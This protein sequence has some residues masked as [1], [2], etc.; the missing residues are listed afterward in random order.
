MDDQLN[1]SA[2]RTGRVLLAVGGTFVVFVLT[3]IALYMMPTLAAFDSLALAAWFVCVGV[4]AFS[5]LLA[6][7]LENTI[8][9]GYLNA[10]ALIVWLTFGLGMALLLVFVGAAL[11]LLLRLQ[12]ARYPGIQQISLTQAVQLL[13]QRISLT[14]LAL[15]GAALIYR[16]LGYTAP[17]V[18]GGLMLLPELMAIGVAFVLTQAI[19]VILADSASR[20]PTVF[21]AGQRSRLFS[22]IILMIAIVPLALVYDTSGPVVFGLLVALLAVQ[23]FRHRQVVRTQQTLMVRVRELSLINSVGQDISGHLLRD[24]VIE[25][26]REWSMSTLVDTP[27]FFIGLYDD[28]RNLLEYPLVMRRGEPIHWN[29]R[30]PQDDPFADVVFHNRTMVIL[31]RKGLMTMV[32]TL[33]AR[34]PDVTRYVGFPLV[35]G[36]KIIGVMGFV[37]DGRSTLSD[38]LSLEAL[39]T[40]SRQISLSL[41]NAML[42]D[43][44]LSLA[45]NLNQINRS[46][47]D[48]MFNLDSKSSLRVACE[49]AMQIMDSS[50]VAIF[51]L[52]GQTGRMTRLVESAGLTAAHRQLYS[53]PTYL[54]PPGIATSRVIPDIHSLDPDEISDVLVK[55]ARAGGFRAMAEVPLKSGNIPVGMLTVFHDVPYHY[56]KMQLELLETL[57][58]QVA[59]A[60]DNAELLSALELYAAEQ[61]QL[62]HLSRIS[63]S[64]LDIDTVMQGVSQLLQQM[65]SVPWVNIGLMPVGTNY[66]QFYR[67]NDQ[68]RVAIVLDELPEVAMVCR[69]ALPGPSVYY[70]GEPDI[71]LQLRTWMAD[72]DLET[73]VLMIMVASNN[74]MGIIMLGDKRHRQFAE[75]ESRLIEMAANQIAT[76][77]HNAQLYRFTQEELD[78]RLQQLALI[79]NIAQHIS[80]ALNL[81]Q[82]I[83]NVLEA[84]LRASQAELAA[85]GLVVDS[86]EMRIITHEI[87]EDQVV[88]SEYRRGTDVGLMGRV[89]NT[90]ETLVIDDNEAYTEYID[91]GRPYA[92]S[93]IVPLIR[94]NRPIGVLNLESNHPAHFNSEQAEFVKSLAG[95]AVISIQNARLLQERQAQIETLTKL[96]Q[97]SLRLSSDTPEEQVVDSVLRTAIDVLQGKNASL[98][99]Y[100][101]RTDKL[102]LN[103]SIRR[104]TDEYFE[105]RIAM[106]ESVPL[107]AARTGELQI[108][109]DVHHSEDFISFVDALGVDYISVVAAPIERGGESRQ[110]LCVTMPHTRPYKDTDQ[111]TLGLLA[112]Q[113]AGHLENARLYQRIR[114]QN[115]RMQAILDSTRDG[116]ILLDR[117]GRLIEVNAS[118]EKLLNIH[119]Q[120]YIGEPFAETFMSDLRARSGDQMGDALLNSFQDMLRV[121]RLEPERITRNSLELR[122]GSEIRYIQEVGSPVIDSRRNII[123]RLLT[124]RD[125]TEEKLLVAYRDEITSMVVHDLRGPLGSIISSLTL[126]QEIAQEIGD[127]TVPSIIEVSLDSAHTL[128]NLV[129]SLLDIAKLE[130]RRMPIKRTPMALRHIVDEAYRALAK[131]VQDAEIWVEFAM[132]SDLPQVDVDGDK[133][134]RVMIN[135]LDNA[136]RYTPS[137]ERI[138]ISAE[139]RN[140]KVVVSVADSGPGIPQ[141]EVNRVFEK[142]RQVQD[143]MP[144]RGRKGSGLGLTFCKLAIEAHEETIWIEQNGPLSGACFMFTLP[145]TSELSVIAQQPLPHQANSD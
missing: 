25:A 10:V 39:E 143:S 129:D 66:L 50:K 70:A 133:I 67:G 68:G 24:D 7:P 42:Y 107:R 56:H 65:L 8:W 127:E 4:Y 57:A 69:Q 110:V 64:S 131:S 18:S 134:R 1:A 135:L 112:I 85:L 71:S 126:T 44:S 49:T 61:A 142:F 130:T 124:L 22:E 34:M 109:Q 106:P 55:L 138:L 38:R 77:V 76:Q 84:S 121:L 16:L 102:T 94:E 93:L 45:E 12:G 136:V 115:N 128:L 23:A 116:I 19:G 104:E 40:I 11:A 74:V 9:A 101:A 60:L 35:S 88:T 87:I 37:E 14:G 82:I 108:V 125:V 96:R 91:E 28:D 122:V 15:L 92:S 99:D 141:E 97:L 105:T 33:V 113:A 41:R 145:I 119:L 5:A 36:G 59:A 54:P 123:G 89:L 51:L 114:S 98:Y 78:R 58:Y 139:R 95:H 3:L 79:E 52:D 53:D 72:E 111:S 13:F 83:A 63:T 31:D 30:R 47:Q 27:L 17:L 81:E 2:L 62:V 73:L 100:D 140:D 137:G 120:D 86:G 29:N 48:V 117:D 20:R 6:G 103:R 75:G 21:Q 32:P 43:R 46:V 26:V 118:A 144:S 132:P 80:S 90:G